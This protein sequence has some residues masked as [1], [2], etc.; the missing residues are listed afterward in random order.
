MI[1]LVVAA[2]PDDEVLGC[3]G[4]IAR[5]TKAGDT[6]HILIVAEGAMSRIEGSADDVDQLIEAAKRA[7]KAL[8][9]E[10]P[11]MLGLPDNR[12]D[13]VAL[14]DVIQPIE[15]VVRGTMPEIVYTHHGNDLNLDHRIV[16]Q[17]TVTACRPLPGST[18]RRLFAFEAPSSTEWSTRSMGPAFNPAHFVGIADTLDA[19]TAALNCYETEM[20]PFPHPRSTEAITALAQV[21]GSHV[22]LAAAEAFEVVLDIRD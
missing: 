3:G 15:D 13:T 14:L 5:H 19:K 18:V 8:G 22:G 11:K 17:A 9:A 6:V 16:H 7:A 10:K 2:H 21:R 4:T 1:V 12:L 20:R